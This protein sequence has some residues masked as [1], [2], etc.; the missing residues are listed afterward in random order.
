MAKAPVGSPTAVGYPA[1]GS[2]PCLSPIIEFVASGVL[3]GGGLGERGVGAK[4]SLR[5]KMIEICGSEICIDGRIV[6]IAHVM[7]TD[8]AS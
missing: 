6:R 4:W 8:I 5:A 1:K 3:I 7:A 2:S